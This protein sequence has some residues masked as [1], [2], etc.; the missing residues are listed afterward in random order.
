MQGRRS[1]ISRKNKSHGA[2]RVKFSPASLVVKRRMGGSDQQNLVAAARAHASCFNF[3]PPSH[4]S[5]TRSPRGE[6]GILREQIC[7]LIEH[8]AARVA[9]QQNLRP[10]DPGL[11]WVEESQIPVVSLS[12]S[13]SR[14]IL[15]CLH[16]HPQIGQAEQEFLT[17]TIQAVGYILGMQS[18]LFDNSGCVRRRAKQVAGILADGVQRHGSL[19]PLTSSFPGL[20]LD[21]SP[22]V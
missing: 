3:S 22:I 19:T 12:F 16:R 11:D 14:S 15:E 20:P 9:R 13:E 4:P 5:Q 18:S 7:R 8:E 21:V 10:S 2:D 6:I 17:Y 1:D